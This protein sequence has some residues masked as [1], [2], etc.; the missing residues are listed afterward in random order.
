MKEFAQA[1]VGI[2]VYAWLHKGV[3]SCAADICRGIENRAY[4]DYCMYRIRMLIHFNAR[5]VVVFDGAALPM[6]SETHEA[7]EKQREESM[8][9]AKEAD[10]AGDRQK[11]VEW[12]QRACPVTPYM[13]REVI[14][15]CRKLNVEYMVAPYEADAQLAW[16]MK[17]GHIDAVI[18]E[19][20]DLLVYGASRVLYKMNRSGQGILFD[21]KNLP[22]LDSLSMNNFTEDM[23]MYMCI[24]SGCDFFKGVLGLGIKKAHAMVKKYKTMSCLIQGIRRDSR[25]KVTPTFT[26]DFVRACL[27][28]RHQT[29]YDVNTSSAVHLT[30]MS[31]SARASLPHGVLTQTENGNYDLS[32]LGTQH[33]AS[34]VKKIAEGFVH[35]KT[36]QEYPEPLD[37]ISRPVSRRPRSRFFQPPDSTPRGSP[38]QHRA[39]VRRVTPGFQVQP[40]SQIVPSSPASGAYSASINLRQRLHARRNRPSVFNP[41][42]A[43]ADFMAKHGSSSSAGGIWAGF[44]PVSARL[45]SEKE[46][47]TN[48]RVSPQPSNDS[49]DVEN[50][51]MDKG[52]GNDPADGNKG[53]SPAEDKNSIEDGGLEEFSDVLGSENQADEGSPTQQVF[54][55]DNPIQSQKRPRTSSSRRVEAVHRALTRFA[56]TDVEA[57]RNKFLA[58]PKVPSS[59]DRDSYNLFESVDENL[60]RDEDQ[61]SAT[62]GP[63]IPSSTLKNVTER[64]GRIARPPQQV[65][66]SRFFPP[67]TKGKSL[68][69]ERKRRPVLPKSGLRAPLLR[70]SISKDPHKKTS[71]LDRFKRGASGK[72]V[73]ANC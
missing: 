25:Y 23:F 17:S 52:H 9:K 8:K 38:P 55:D 2:D 22:S 21:R 60:S 18:T 36:L 42:R 64:P 31:E 1:R 41:R 34:I 27:V 59:P 67:S 39:E 63:I 66:L 51:S 58:L 61:D 6:K 53:V 5:P 35:P 57:K 47:A 37:M 28:F 4:V 43:G 54:T 30:E 40:A 73:V 20:S 46:I 71:S 68:P 11:A 72:K 13:A 48:L 19:D 15:E 16:M 32:F 24:C 50:D 3:F 70:K 44:R 69:G 26:S 49:E 10:A 56:S 33:D 62:V 65:R 14:R 12:Y 45:D 7:R 29:V